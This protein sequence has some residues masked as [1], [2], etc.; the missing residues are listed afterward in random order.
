MKRIAL[1]GAGEKGADTR[2]LNLE[3]AGAGLTLPGDKETEEGQWAQR[4]S[5]LLLRRL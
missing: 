2:R 5:R 4:P 1:S 3:R